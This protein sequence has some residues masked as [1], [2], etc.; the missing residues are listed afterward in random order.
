MAIAYREETPHQWSETL[1]GTW[2]VVEQADGY[3]LSGQCPTCTDACTVTIDRV[4]FVPGQAGERKGRSDVEQ[5]TIVCNC[6]AEHPGAPPGKRGCGR[7]G[8]LTLTPG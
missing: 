5:L 2:N 1:A 4:R 7:G 8:Y 6:P 3:V